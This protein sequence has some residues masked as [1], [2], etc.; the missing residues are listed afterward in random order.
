LNKEDFEF[1]SHR[2]IIDEI[3]GKGYGRTESGERLLRMHAPEVV[4]LI[5]TARRQ[6]KTCPSRSS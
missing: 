4:E 6:A 1:S 3:A 5:L 2:S